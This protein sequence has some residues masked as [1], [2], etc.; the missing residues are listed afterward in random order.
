IRLVI[1]DDHPLIL[2][3]LTDLFSTDRELQVVARCATAGD[4][5]EAVRRHRPDVLV[6]DMRM[7]GPDAGMSVLRG[8]SEDGR[9]TATVLYTASLD[10]DEMLEAIRLGVRG[11]VLKE[12]PPRLLVEC[13]YA[14]HAGRHVLEKTL[15]TQAIHTLLRRQAEI[16]DVAS[17]LSEREI[18]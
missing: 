17:P 12:M 3:G 10:E 2:D 1:A 8:L 15:A 9:P 14:V 11:V 13:V 6:L 5:L 4:T 7:P 18:E 16:R